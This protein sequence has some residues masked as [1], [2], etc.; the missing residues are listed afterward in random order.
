MMS[1]ETNLLGSPS[2]YGLRRLKSVL[3]AKGIEWQQHRN[4]LVL[5]HK[6]RIVYGG[7][8]GQAARTL[9][10]SASVVPPTA[11]ESLCIRLIGRGEEAALVLYGSDER[12]LTYA[13]YEASRAIELDGTAAEPFR[14]IEE[15]TESPDLAVRSVIRTMMNR[16]LDVEWL[17][18]VEFWESYLDMLVATRHNR[19]KLSVGWRS[20]YFSPPFPF[21]IDVHGYDGVSVTNLSAEER[22]HNLAMLKAI[23]SM[24][25]DRGL[26][27]Y[28][29]TYWMSHKPMGDW[30]EARKYVVEGLTDETLPDYTR[31]G[32]K[33]LLRECTDIDGIGMSGSMGENGVNQELFYSLFDGISECGRP[34]EIQIELKGVSQELVDQ[35]TRRGISVTLGGKYCMEHKGLPYH[36]TQIR[37][38]E[39]ESPDH[40]RWTRN[41]YADM[42]YRPRSHDF[43]FNLWNWG[44]QKV[45]LW[46]DTEDV[47]KLARNSLISGSLGMEHGDPL[48]YKGSYSSGP[49]GYWRIFKDRSLEN[50]TWEYGRYWYH[51]LLYG[52]L[53]YNTHTS[54]KVWAREFR[55]R[56]GPQASHHLVKALA[57]ASRVTP[58]MTTVHAPSASDNYY[59]P[60]VYTNIPIAMPDPERRDGGDRFDLCNPSDTALFYRV[61]DYVRDY[62]GDRLSAKYSPAI[63]RDWFLNIGS[64][65][66]REM[67]SAEKKISDPN[68]AEFRATS[69]DVIAQANL[70]LFFGHKIEA[71]VQFGFYR[72]RGDFASLLKAIEAYEQALKFWRDIVSATKDR[73]QPNLAFHRNPI[74]SGSW[75]DREPAIVEDLNQMKMFRDNFLS[76]YAKSEVVFGH[77][78]VWIQ[79]PPHL[80]IETMLKGWE[81]IETVKLYYKTDG[82]TSYSRLDMKQDRSA[83]PVYR[84]ECEVLPQ[85]TSFEYYMEA[86]LKT[87]RRVAYP[88][89]NPL[90]IVLGPK[91]APPVC[92]HNPPETFEAG[93]PLTLELEVSS[94]TRLKSVRLRYRH[95]NQ[96]EYVLG[97]D[98]KGENGSYRGAIPA[99]YTD[100][101]YDLMYYFEVIDEMGNSVIH[102]GLEG[103]FDAPYFVVE[104]SLQRPLR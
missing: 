37:L 28:F 62:L 81:R 56:F 82:Q 41:S 43:M 18:S 52:R 71:A 40:R 79:H 22:D 69:M 29:D 73:Y 45:L 8:G 7:P 87:G 90:K 26:E 102:P 85:A 33:K 2:M 4:E 78:P 24:A 88:Q 3:T 38:E 1:I 27:F 54:E 61:E 5:N 96:S 20:A 13:L 19:L 55:G 74:M 11:P 101:L 9:L 95:V 14:G 91:V 23:S 104:R 36:P 64:S 93:K 103:N 65:A 35:A 15:A 46:G 25:K 92:Q 66:L 57:Y 34:M 50:Y 53:M 42:L 17:N 72:E 49:S 86:Q 10:D 16:E 30:A 84:A 21:L 89:T 63:V 77:V 32:I 58:L 75:E 67:E 83:P 68:S 98:M 47:A 70:S 12:G 59:W 80:R 97:M 100:S 44:T 6:W 60:E 51:Y 94:T 99:S 39:L 31:R 76:Q 48:T